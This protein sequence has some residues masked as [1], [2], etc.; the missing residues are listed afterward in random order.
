MK[1]E[2]VSL[3]DITRLYERINLIDP[4]GAGRIGQKGSSYLAR[5]SM[6]DADLRQLIRRYSN[7][8]MI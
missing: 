2:R 1:K 6:K 8:S 5:I 7:E 3:G 4:K